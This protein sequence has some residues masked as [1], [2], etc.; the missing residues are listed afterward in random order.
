MP[1]S[2]SRNYSITMNNPKVSLE[3][4]MDLLKRGF[5]IVYARVQLEKGEKGTPH[6]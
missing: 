4:F 1:S 5:D 3:E 2:K 6:I